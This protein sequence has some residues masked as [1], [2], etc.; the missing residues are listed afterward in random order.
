[1]GLATWLRISE[2]VGQR[3]DGEGV[4]PRNRDRGDAG[5]SGGGRDP[6]V[7]ELQ[8]AVGGGDQSPFR[9]RGPA[10]SSESGYP[11]VVLKL[12]KDR[13]DAVSSFDVE[14]TA[15]ILREHTAHEGEHPVI[16]AG[17]GSSRAIESGATSAWDPSASSCSIY[18]P[19]QHSVEV[20]PRLLPPECLPVG[21]YIDH[22]DRTL[23]SLDH[24]K[25]S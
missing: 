2:G 5:S 1:M 3:S 8:E 9:S 10:S 23:L 13:L 14:L 19:S 17:R 20:S 15:E 6:V 4:V 24:V 22:L 16:P 25:L 21:R 18:G 12:P 7:V 11:A